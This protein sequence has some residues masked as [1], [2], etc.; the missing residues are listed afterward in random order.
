[1]W[2][3]QGDGGYASLVHVVDCLINVLKGKNFRAVAFAD[4]TAAFG[5][6]DQ[7]MPWDIV[8]LDCFTDDLFRDTVAVDV[9]GVPLR[10]LSTFKS[11]K[12]PIGR[13]N[14]VQA[15]IV[16]GLEQR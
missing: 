1:M 15:S 2:E 10:L 5:A 16:S 14:R 11:W 13:T 9:R 12:R 6:Y 4:C 3:G 8:F 7:F